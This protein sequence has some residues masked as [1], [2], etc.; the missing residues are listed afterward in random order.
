VQRGIDNLVR[1]VGETGCRVIVDH[2]AVR[3]PRFRDR[4]GAAFA[5]GR[6]VTAAEYLGRGDE[7]LEAQR[8]AL[9][10]RRRR[11]EP[12]ARATATEP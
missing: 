11:V 1:L 12:G 2:H 5:T 8:A 10:A 3:E 7:C 6:V 9:W 4:L